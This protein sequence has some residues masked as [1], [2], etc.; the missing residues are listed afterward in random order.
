MAN[1]VKKEKVDI[2]EVGEVV[3]VTGDL[4]IVRKR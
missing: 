4:N 2:M 3:T 1:G